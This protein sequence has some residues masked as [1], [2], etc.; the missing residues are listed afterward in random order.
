MNDVIS[1]DSP[2]FFR[3]LL[4]QSPFVAMLACAFFGVAYTS[5]SRH[6]MTLYWMILVPAFGAVCVATAWRGTRENERWRAAL[7]QA[8]HW[9]AV[10]LAMQL[11]LI[12]DMERAMSAEA[13]ALVLLVIL[14]LG[15]VTAGLHLRA[16]PIVIVGAVLA[17][18]VP[19]FAWL[20]ERTLLFA[21]A[22]VGVAAVVAM[23]V[24]LRSRLRAAAE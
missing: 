21:L 3:L 14:A 23:A 15:A 5:V 20:E 13:S 17:M 22:T 7:L 12:A 10:T 9:G 11:A 4:A 16:W 8:L 19:I 6:E 24:A 2:G 1:R 18:G